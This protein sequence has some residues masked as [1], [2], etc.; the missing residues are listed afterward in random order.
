MQ[1][2]RGC[3]GA[4]RLLRCKSFLHELNLRRSVF[5]NEIGRDRAE[6]RWD[7][8]SLLLFRQRTSFGTIHQT[9]ESPVHLFDRHLFFHRKNAP[10]IAKWICQ[11]RVPIAVEL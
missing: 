4:E 1:S 2:S 8:L 10:S 7:W 9:A 6:S 5:A 11:A 3:H